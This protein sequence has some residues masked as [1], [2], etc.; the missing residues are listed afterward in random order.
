MEGWGRQGLTTCKGVVTYAET[1]C[2]GASLGGVR[3][4][5]PWPILG[6]GL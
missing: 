5:H 3:V 4:S 1:E 6:R 2:A